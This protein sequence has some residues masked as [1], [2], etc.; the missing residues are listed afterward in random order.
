MIDV[1]TCTRDGRLAVLELK[2][3]EDLHLPLQGLDYWARVR[4]HNERGEFKKFGYFAGRELS[5]ASPLLFL[6][7]PAL[8]VHP[9]TD[10]LLKHLANEVEWE[11]VA[12]DEHWREILRVIFRKRP[13]E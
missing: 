7:T 3:S 9:E 6:V 4:W 1:L 13:R 2:A 11:L 12:V 5:P 8:H 10:T